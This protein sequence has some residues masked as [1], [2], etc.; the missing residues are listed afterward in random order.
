MNIK[1]VA[2]DCF[3]TVF[4]MSN[5]SRDQ[6]N[7]YVDHVNKKDFSPY[8]FPNNWYNLKSHS[9]SANGIKL[10]QDK[11]YYCVA[12]SNGSYDLI[13]NISERNNIYWNYIVDLNKHKVYKPHFD[14]Y[15]TIEKDTNFKPFETLMVTANPK[16]G[17]IEGARNINMPSAIIRHGYLNTIPEL[18]GYIKNLENLV[19]N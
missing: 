9:D 4:D 3:G 18:V 7:N 5:I 13:K 6:I 10:L 12:L 8:I 16:F 17:D 15:K 14:A 11:G 19:N 2:F 1:C